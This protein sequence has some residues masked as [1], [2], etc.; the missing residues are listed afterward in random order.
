MCRSVESVTY[1][2]HFSIPK[3]LKDCSAPV[4][5]PS[6]PKAFPLNMAFRLSL[7]SPSSTIGNIVFRGP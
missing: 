7:T 5:M 1:L 3:S 2:C 6:I 4:G